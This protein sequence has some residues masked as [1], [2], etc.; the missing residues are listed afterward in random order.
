MFQISGDD[1]CWLGD[2]NV[3]YIDCRSDGQMYEDKGFQYDFKLAIDLANKEFN[4]TSEM[5]EIKITS[6]LDELI[7]KHKNLDVFANQDIENCSPTVNPVGLNI[8][9]KSEETISLSLDESV[10]HRS[11]FSTKFSISLSVSL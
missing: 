1:I 6:P 3:H 2:I 9:K 10:I 4:V 5:N 7:N 8:E 11:S